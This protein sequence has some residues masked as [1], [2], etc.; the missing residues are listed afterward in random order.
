M[1]G[2]AD[3]RGVICA[4]QEWSI[5][6]RSSPPTKRPEANGSGRFA[7]KAG[8]IADTTD[9]AVDFVKFIF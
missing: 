5:P 7:K 2:I 8:T 6:A 1:A 3:L 4:E 9:V